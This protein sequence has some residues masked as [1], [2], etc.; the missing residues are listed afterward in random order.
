[1]DDMEWIEFMGEL[2]EQTDL[3]RR[4]V[5]LL[6]ELVLVSKPPRFSRFYN[7]T[8][9]NTST[10]DFQ[11]II[12]FPDDLAGWTIWNLSPLQSVDFAF[13]QSAQNFS[14]IGPGGSISQSSHPAGIYCR[15]QTGS[16][17]A[18]NVRI[19]LWTYKA[20]YDEP[21]YKESFIAASEKAVKK[22]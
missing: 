17:S 19:L 13:E 12:K 18:V 4:A 1:M 14:Q 7:G 10:Q 20:K 11:L 21:D 3:L 6:E 5:T 16:A 9:V 22:E 8:V 2:F 15:R